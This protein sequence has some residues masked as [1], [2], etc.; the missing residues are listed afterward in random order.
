MLLQMKSSKRRVAIR[1][2]ASE[3]LSKRAAAHSSKSLA[4]LV[5]VAKESPFAKVI[6]MIETLLSK[7]QEEAAAEATHKEWCDEQLK[8]NKLKREEKSANVDRLTAEAEELTSTI[9]TMASEID[10]LLK[11]QEKLTK[12]MDE[13]TTLRAS[14]KAENEQAIS[15]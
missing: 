2:R 15:D 10:T 9:A 8:E 13:A 5:A 12:E 11:E 1:D 3:F 4:N 7:L 14:E 6:E